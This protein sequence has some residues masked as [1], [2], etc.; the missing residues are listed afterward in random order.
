MS[1]RTHVKRLPPSFKTKLIQSETTV[2][3]LNNTMKLLVSNASE[4]GKMWDSVQPLFEFAYQEA[5]ADCVKYSIDMNITNVPEID[6]TVKSKMD[7]MTYVLYVLIST[8][9]CKSLLLDEF[10]KANYNLLSTEGEQVLGNYKAASFDPKTLPE[11]ISSIIAAMDIGE[12]PA[13]PSPEEEE[14]H[15]GT[16]ETYVGIGSGS[17]AYI[18]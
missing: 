1:L 4:F 12:P 7:Y 14:K 6:E 11:H 2:S 17:S 10:E 3:A 18:R 8:S 16:V 13:D 5:E 15:E 9:H